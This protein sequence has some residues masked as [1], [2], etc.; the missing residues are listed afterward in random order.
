[1][2]IKQ[3][4]RREE[5]SWC[6]ITVSIRRFFLLSFACTIVERKK[7]L[8]LHPSATLKLRLDDFRTSPF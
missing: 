4:D 8:F 2:L 6:S 3:D 5:L 1:M 7:Q